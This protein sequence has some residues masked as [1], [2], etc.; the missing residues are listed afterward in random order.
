M[1]DYLSSLTLQN[2]FLLGKMFKGFQKFLLPRSTVGCRRLVLAEIRVR[3]LRQDRRHADA[4]RR[5]VNVVQVGDALRNARSDGGGG[6]VAGRTFL[7]L[8]G[9]F[10]N[11]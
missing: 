7:K 3:F 9:R 8:K 4:R 11:L 1:N 2:E 5:R 6:G 10:V